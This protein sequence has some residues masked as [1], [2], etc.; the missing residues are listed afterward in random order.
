MNAGIKGKRLSLLIFIPLIS[1]V[2]IQCTIIKNFFISDDFIHLYQ[3]AN[4]DFWEFLIT[5]HGGHVLPVLSSLFYIFL[6]LFGINSQ[7]YFIIV[8]LT[9][10]INVALLYYVILFFTGKRNIALFFS[11]LWGISP[12]N[13]ASLGWFSAFGYV[14]VVTFLL[15]ILLDIGRIKTAAMKPHPVMFIKWL[16]ILLLSSLTFGVGMSITM[17][18]FMVSWLLLY[19]TKYRIKTTLFLIGVATTVP[20]TYLCLMHLYSR[21]S[22]IS[23][24]VPSLPYESLHFWVLTTKMLLN[25]ISY[26]MCTLLTGPYLIFSTKLAFPISYIAI[27]VVCLFLIAAFIRASKYSRLQMLAYLL[28][29]LTVSFFISFGRANACDWFKTT[30]QELIITSERYFYVINIIC[31]L[32]LSVGYESFP[33]M[34]KLKTRLPDYILPTFIIAILFIPSLWCVKLVIPNSGYHARNDFHTMTKQIEKAI[35]VNQPKENYYFMNMDINTS[36]I[37][38]LG[39]DKSNFPGIAAMYVIA[40]PCNEFSGKRVYFVEKDHELVYKLR[41]IKN[42]RISELLVTEEEAKGHNINKIKF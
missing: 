1:S 34:K 3:A 11:T 26:G 5:P 7:Y 15:L 10:L 4:M 31:S 22:G 19:E 36:S 24:M 25:M 18:F 40:F 12:I 32:L 33:F 23:S 21:I 14:I 13:Q 9:H 27:S 41:K 20:I 30:T 2:V 38:F 37:F 28:L 39:M 35:D 17:S 29:V 16:I 42:S 8:L 6:K